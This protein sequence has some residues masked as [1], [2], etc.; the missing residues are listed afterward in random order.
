[1]SPILS[2]V[3]AG[4]VCLI[5]GIVAGI[6]IRKSTAEKESGSAEQEAT[7]IVNVAIKEAENKKRE[8]VLEASE[9][10]QRERADLDAE[11]K[12]RRADLQKQERRL[13]QKEDNLDRKT[14]AMEKKEEKLKQVRQ[15]M[16]YY[17]PTTIKLLE[18]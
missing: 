15:F 6:Q 14:D 11:S 5:I 13:R 4:V 9:A 2:A 3:I 8:M 7:R 1:M 18:Q 16:N 12:E 17:L 10:I